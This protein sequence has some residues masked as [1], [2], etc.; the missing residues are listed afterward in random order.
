MFD[1][2]T[3]WITKSIKRKDKAICNNFK[4]IKKQSTYKLLL[5]LNIKKKMK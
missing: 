5:S 3:V 2:L 1:Y 4:K